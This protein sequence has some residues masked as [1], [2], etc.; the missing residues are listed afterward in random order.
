M[1]KLIK[2]SNKVKNYVLQR[3][4]KNPQLSCRTLAIDVSS[5]YNILLSKSSINS[6]IKKAKLSSP[7]GRNVTKIHRPN[8]EAEYVGFAFIHAANLMLNFPK[9]LAGVIKKCYP[10]TKLKIDTL[11]TISE[12]WIMAKA[13]YNLPLNKI[14]NY[15]KNEIWFLTGR[16]V[17]KGLL[18][19]Y[20]DTLK[21]SQHIA[22]N[23]FS[24]MSH[25]IQDVHYIKFHLAGGSEFLLDGRL[26]S[27]WKKPEIP[28]EL[29]TTI[30][31]ANSYINN[32]I[33]GKEPLVVFCAFP[34]STLGD[35]ISDFIF[36]L[37]GSSSSK[38]IRSI[39]FVSPQGVTIKDVPFVA[40][41]RRSFI[42]GIWPWQYKYISEIE[43]KQ[44]TG[45]YMLEPTG[46]EFYFTEEN[47]RFAQHVKNIDVML[48][49]I[50]VKS[51]PD[52]PAKIAIFTNLSPEEYSA[53]QVVAR[54]VY[55]WP[56][57][58]AGH[59]LFLKAA[60]TPIYLEDFISSDRLLSQA[61]AIKD[62]DDPDAIFSNI[63]DILNEYVKREFFPEECA[64]WSLLKMRELFYRKNG[65][66]ARDMADDVLYKIFNI[67]ELQEIS[68]FH[69]AATKFNE[70][71]CI[72]NSGRKL[73]L[74]IQP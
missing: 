57:V 20:L 39:E 69:D 60:K 12:A 47:I 25:A 22:N 70:A 71:H 66:I 65:F 41:D 13:L 73:W 19:R 37:D 30:D 16:K 46:Q 54:Y 7:V 14:A 11:E 40:P 26:K 28:T 58:M 3:K 56:D 59:R 6:I 17:N 10:E 32:T 9:I 33:F 53:Q 42:V 67:N 74:T 2:I 51:A 63:V 45:K 43:K 18:K 21:S 72:D 24:E 62:A 31:I 23:M 27:I 8:G 48:R 49:L 61:R 50:V 34:E 52:G 5:K 29:S 4:R 36:S 68:V 35:E 55:K 1:S 15:T 64:G 44:A 38:R